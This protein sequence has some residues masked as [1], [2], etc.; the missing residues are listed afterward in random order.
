L[1]PDIVDGSPSP[2]DEAHL[3]RRR[4]CVRETVGTWQFADRLVFEMKLAGFSAD[5]IRA[6][7]RRFDLPLTS[8]AIHLK[9]FRLLRKLRQ[10]CG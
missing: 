7:A 3:R 5:E 2:E 6:E 9:W 4:D 8:G 1:P 10:R